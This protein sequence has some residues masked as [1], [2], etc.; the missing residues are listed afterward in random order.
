M[1][2]SWPKLTKGCG[3][4][5]NG[6]RQECQVAV[7]EFPISEQ[8]SV[9]SSDVRVVVCELLDLVEQ[10]NRG[11][12]HGHIMSTVAIVLRFIRYRHGSLV[13]EMISSPMAS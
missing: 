10:E 11:K 8:Y 2:R 6:A 3:E 12:R 4:N 5:T 7:S 13:G 9:L 1:T